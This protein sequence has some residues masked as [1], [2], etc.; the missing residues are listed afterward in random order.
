MVKKSDDYLAAQCG[1]S[2][3]LMPL[4]QHVNFSG[5]IFGQRNINYNYL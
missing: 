1:Q 3:R 5:H 4:N 2:N